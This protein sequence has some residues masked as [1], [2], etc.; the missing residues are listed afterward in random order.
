MIRGR[1]SC[2][3]VAP[4]PQVGNLTSKTFSVKHNESQIK[5]LATCK[6]PNNDVKS[7]RGLVTWLV[8]WIDCGP[9]FCSIN[10]FCVTGTN[11]KG[12]SAAESQLDAI[13]IGCGGHV[14]WKVTLGV[15][16]CVTLVSFVACWL[17]N[18][19]EGGG[20]WE[21]HRQASPYFTWLSVVM[22]TLC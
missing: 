7:R 3:K 6:G 11:D 19:R 20:W 15:S 9:S 22:E 5:W 4:D 17:L 14:W 13:S 16:V 21:R 10:S 18:Y 8:A 12:Q 1:N 2:A